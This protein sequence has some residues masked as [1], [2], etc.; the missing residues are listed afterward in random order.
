MS[1]HK[2]D[3]KSIKEL[4]EEYG[5]SCCNFQIFDMNVSDFINKSSEALKLLHTMISLHGCVYIHCTA[6]I[7]RSPQLAILYLVRFE[8][9]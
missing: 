9:Y 5:M 3:W 2:V 8:N 7:Y 4:A 1:K 6:G